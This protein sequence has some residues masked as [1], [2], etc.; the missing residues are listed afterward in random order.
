[1]KKFM[2]AILAGC[3]VASA[4]P[5]NARETAIDDGNEIISVCGDQTYFSSGYCLGYIRG[6]SHGA[7]MY[8][9]SKNTNICYPNNVTVGQLRDVVV[10]YIRRNP[11]KRTESAMLLVARA[12]IEA[13]PC[14]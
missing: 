14:R 1:M 8:F 13:W 6:V 3:F 5:A 2:A 11:A 4:F 12:S 10:D 7:D 9:A